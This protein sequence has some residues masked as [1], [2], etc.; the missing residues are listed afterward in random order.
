MGLFQRAAN[1][2]GI[3]SQPKV[4]AAQVIDLLNRGSSI[5]SLG[6]D[7]YNIPEVRTAINFIAEKV[8]SVPFYHA[9][10][11]ND[12]NVT[13]LNDHVQYVLSV[14]ANPYQS[15]QVFW[16]YAIT[17]LMLANNVYI[18]PDWDD[19]GN[20]RALF[21][22][23]FTQH[24]FEEKE[25]VLRIK[26]PAAAGYDFAY[27]DI[28]HLQRFPTQNGGATRQATSGYV[29]IVNTLQEQAVKDSENSQRIAALLI[30][31]SSLKGTDMKKKLEEFKELFLTAENTTGFGMIGSEFEVHDLDLKMSPLNKD[32]LETIVNY[33]YTYFGGSKAI[34]THS[35]NELEHEQFIDNT[36]KP[37]VFQIE[38]ES[39]YKL[40]SSK[41]IGRFHKV[42]A[43]L[44]DL[45][46]STLGAKTTFFKEMLFASVMTRNE[47][48]KRIG[49]PKGPQ[50][51]DAYMES[52]NFQTLK[53]GSYTVEGGETDETGK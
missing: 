45:E 1:F 31:K 24:T 14:R 29:Q 38:E 36:I 46:V 17:R 53:P 18:F 26:F 13:Q 28:I 52:K 43:E 41:E 49:L 50:Q 48:R 39:T 10:A 33:L 4:T 3:S 15:P 7:L 12:G 51:L 34:F 44:I 42:L 8:G 35:A 40:F 27:D 23:P 11:D 20:L 21:V 47:V 25:G 5:L 2:L 16:T 9:R 32:V 19:N 37:I 22:L 30:N 6:K